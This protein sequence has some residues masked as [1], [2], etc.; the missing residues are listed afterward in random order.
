VVFGAAAHT[1][2]ISMQASS[3]DN[4]SRQFHFEF[5]GN[6]LAC[7][8]ASFCG[9]FWGYVKRKVHEARSSSTD[10]LKQRIRYGIQG[11]HSETLRRVTTLFP[12]RLQECIEQHGGHLQRVILKQ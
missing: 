7:P 4:V 8:L 9:S 2:Q 12:S 6:N 3:Q 11:I 5:R 10:H 1:A